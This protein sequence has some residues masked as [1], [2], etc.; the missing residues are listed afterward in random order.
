MTAVAQTPDGYLWVGTYNG[1]AR[2]DGVNFVTFDPDNTP[3]LAHARV[4]QLFLDRQGALWI[5]TFDGSLTRMRDGKFVREWTAKS[6]NDRDNTLISSTSDAIAFA[7]DQGDFFKKELAAPPGEGWMQLAVPNRNLLTAQTPAGQCLAWFNG[8]GERSWAKRMWR[9][10]ENHFHPIPEVGSLAGR[11][12]RH[13]A[14]VA[15]NKFWLGTDTSLY[16]WNGER[17]IESTPTNGAAQSDFSFLCPA[18]DGGLWV[19]ADGNLGK[20]SGRR[21]LFQSPE[22]K[23]SSASRGQR[24]D[25]NADQAGG[26]WLHDTSRGI[27]HM[28]GDGRL[29]RFKSS[30][31]GINDR[32]T[33]LFADREG[34][35]WAGFELAGLARIREGRFQQPTLGLDDAGRSARSVCVDDAGNVWIG[36]VGGGLAGLIG[37]TFTNISFPGDM[38]RGSVVS[39][40]SDRHDQLW[41]S[42]AGEKE[43]LMVVSNR[44]VSAVNP[45]LYNVKVIY[46]SRK[47]GKIWAGTRGGLYVSEDGQKP[48]HPVTEI[49]SQTV[50][51]LA[52]DFRGNLWCGDDGGNLYRLTD[53]AVEAFRSEENPHGQAIWAILPQTN[54]VL[55][56]GTFRGGL[57]RFKEGRFFCYTKAEGLPDNVVS[58]IL[59]DDSGHLWLGTHQGIFRV[60]KRSLDEVAEGRRRTVEGVIFGRADGLPSL[61][62]SG[63]YNPSAWRAGD[64]TLWFS[65]LKGPV[66][67]EPS[68]VQ[69]NQRP[70]EVLIEEVIANG[71]QLWP[72][73]GKAL[74][75]GRA[76]SESD[77]AWQ[78]PAGQGQMEFRFIG[79]SLS[80]PERVKYRYKLTGIDEEWV[81]A[82]ERSFVHYASISPGYYNFMVTA[83]NAEG[84]WNPKPVSFPFEVLPHFYETIWFRV[85]VLVLAIVTIY[86][87]VRYRYRQRLRR[88]AEQLERKA[89]IEQ[90]RARIAKDIHDDLG[91]S[92][93]LIA[94]MGDLAR[95]DQSGERIGKISSTARQA[96]KLLDEIVWAVNPRNDSLAQ[97]VEY[98]CGFAADYLGA[99]DIRCRL[100]VPDRMPSIEFSS[101]TRHNVYLAS[102]EAL[103]NVVKHSQA[104]VVELR[105]AVE[106]DAVVIVIR[107]DGRGFTGEPDNAVAD[108]LRNMRQRMEDIG[109]QCRIVT[110]TG[111]SGGTEVAL[112]FP[113]G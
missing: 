90:E 22:L 16:F 81:D 110:Y 103:Q 9:L 19:V 20:I 1:L 73:N 52:E 94:V 60:S 91:S 84:G 67:I 30:A 15:E 108:G 10:E 51:A 57:L 27:L 48:F 53:G 12:I 29:T 104:K 3:A 74:G 61:E 112:R 17:F 77:R 21:W 109:G 24:F 87:I 111:G 69:L 66:F 43:R 75:W 7:L 63:G 40:Y 102:K 68:T 78:I 46:A 42:A 64:G 47:S 107:D 56:I 25:L 97:L 50:R 113:L 18:S 38:P 105:V 89:A 33:C 98:V 37:D 41:V 5:N 49:S 95:Q 59:D 100:E 2:F 83:C 26:V 62:C 14:P 88:Q 65:T 28:T 85:V 80:A 11:R 13:V 8:Q 35:W 23:Y 79:L 39:V 92:L 54:G 34:N 6:Q 4:R 106:K 96:V 70:P 101:K 44:I 45:P 71:K 93:S 58:Q 32:V 86:Q 99:A 72:D 36:L 76:L 55:W 31:S 82:G